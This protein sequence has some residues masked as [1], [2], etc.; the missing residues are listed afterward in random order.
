MSLFLTDIFFRVH[1]AQSDISR[2]ALF[3]AFSLSFILFL[4]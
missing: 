3:N 4:F 1:K 2:I